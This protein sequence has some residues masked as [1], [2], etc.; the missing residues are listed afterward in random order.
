I[1]KCVDEKAFADDPLRIM[2]ALRFACQLD[3]TIE[4]NTH[5]L[6]KLHKNKLFEIPG[7]RKL[8]ELYKMVNTNITSNKLFAY[9]KSSKT[10]KEVFGV[11][12]S[13]IR[14]DYK[15]KELA[16]FLHLISYSDTDK[17]ELFTKT[18][19]IS[20]KTQNWL[21]AFDYWR[22]NLVV[23][24]KT[25]NRKLF[26]KVLQIAKDDS[27]INSELWPA[28]LR[29]DFDKKE[30]N[31]PTHKHQIDIS[32]LELMNEF[33]LKGSE[34]NDVQEK[35]LDAIFRDD[36]K[37]NNWEIQKFLYKKMIK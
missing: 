20:V 34:I 5:A 25:G 8:D 12:F 1:I 2:R 10:T 21:K 33:G 11:E 23:T 32:G 28:S 9:F 37:N 14:G 36:L 35:I 26:F 13:V 3:F 31:L 29:Y 4:K 30:K 15:L 24:E 17:V 18:L 16:E 19:T 22:K 27:I 7:E 6:I